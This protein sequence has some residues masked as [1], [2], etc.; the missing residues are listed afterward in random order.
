[1]NQK[2]FPSIV[3]KLNNSLVSAQ[4]QWRAM[5]ALAGNLEVKPA[6]SLSME[7]LSLKS[8][9]AEACARVVED[10]M[11]ATG[12][13]SFY[14]KNTLERIFRDV[15]ASRFHPLPVWEQIAFTGEYLIQGEER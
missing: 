13:Q 3:G 10:A 12:G 4:T 5:V 9:V 2:Q 11:D 7:M 15:Q 14:R 8:N 1:R 6:R